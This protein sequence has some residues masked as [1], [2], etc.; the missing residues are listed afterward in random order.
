[1]S[2]P[3]P[4]PQYRPSWRDTTARVLCNAILRT[5]ATPWYRS[6]VTSYMRLGV[7]AYARAAS[8]LDDPPAPGDPDG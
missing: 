7:A 4:G 1:V 6:R 3:G 2:F 5:V 8:V